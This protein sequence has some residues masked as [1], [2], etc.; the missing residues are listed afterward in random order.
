MYSN[1]Y[2]ILAQ[3]GIQCDRF[4]MLIP[5]NAAFT[6]NWYTTAQRMCDSSETLLGKYNVMYWPATSSVVTQMRK[7]SRET[8]T[9]VIGIP[10][11]LVYKPCTQSHS[12]CGSPVMWVQTG[13][14]RTSPTS[15]HVWWCT[16]GVQIR[17]SVNTSQYNLETRVSSFEK[18][19]DMRWDTYSLCGRCQ[20]AFSPQHLE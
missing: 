13:L 15:L 14:E 6:Y 20:P 16:D 12:L 11:S 9:D 10:N 7:H 17:D 2:C 5:F 18:E 8:G 3:L 4:W 19:E 1:Y